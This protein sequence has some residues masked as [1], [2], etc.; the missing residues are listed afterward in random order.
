M[1][2]TAG[3]SVGVS[4]GVRAGVRVLEESLAF[5]FFLEQAGL[6]FRLPMGQ[7]GAPGVG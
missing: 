2:Q 5:G 7:D 3:V 4:V 6:E 1:F